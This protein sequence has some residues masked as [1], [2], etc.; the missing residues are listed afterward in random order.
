DECGAECYEQIAEPDAEKWSET[1]YGDERQETRTSGGEHHRERQH[2]RH[3]RLRPPKQQATEAEK[4]IRKDRDNEDRLGI[5]HTRG[6]SISAKTARCFV[7]SFH[8][9]WSDAVS[10]GAHSPVFIWVF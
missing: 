9:N 2:A 1:R 5:E 6:L 4:R 3:L 8:Q 7:V 10:I